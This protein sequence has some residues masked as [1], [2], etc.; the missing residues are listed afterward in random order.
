MTIDEVSEKLSISKHSLRYYEKVGL[1]SNVD[2]TAGNIRDYNIANINRIEFIQKM[3]TAGV[4]I[5]SLK[6][7]IDLAIEGDSTISQRKQ[8]LID[9]QAQIA[10]K[11]KQLETTLEY[12]DH[13]IENY[14]SVLK[15]KQI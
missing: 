3:R 1:I 5:S 15:N 8:I 7:Y 14:D 6:Q 9:Q 10:N 12:L 4:G 2:R 13:K 11:I